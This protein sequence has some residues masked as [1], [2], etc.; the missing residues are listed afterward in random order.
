MAIDTADKRR[1]AAQRTWWR[2]A[3]VPDGSLTN[4][5]DR[6]HA[7]GIYRGLA[8]AFTPSSDMLQ[9]AATEGARLDVAGVTGGRLDGSALVGGRLDGACFTGDRMDGATSTGGRLDGAR[10]TGGRG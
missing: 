9:V 4:E 2:I 6:Q 1:S 3:P 7:A 10:V 5:R 8:L